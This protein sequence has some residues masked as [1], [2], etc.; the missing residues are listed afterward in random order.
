MAESED[1]RKH[2]AA[3]MAESTAPAT[4]RSK[5]RIVNARGN[6]IA[7]HLNTL[8]RI[9]YFRAMLDRGWR[10]SED[11][12]VFVPINAE[13][14]HVIL[15][16]MEYAK[17][18]DAAP[19]EFIPSTVA[20]ASVL[21][22]AAMLGLVEMQPEVEPAGADIP[23]ETLLHTFASLRR[24]RMLSLRALTHT[25]DCR[26]CGN[27][28]VLDLNNLEACACHPTVH[29]GRCTQCGLLGGPNIRGF[30]YRGPHLPRVTEEPRQG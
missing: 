28:F 18:A 21:G 27:P 1:G 29:D 7:V 15:D 3:R 12:E 5:T 16:I 9:P 14:F 6:K 10:D 30:C 25:M 8:Q 13:H 11:P 19:E 2:K 20:M 17:Q 23:S 24:G 26:M 22:A 4:V